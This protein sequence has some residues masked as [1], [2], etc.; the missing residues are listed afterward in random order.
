[1]CRSGLPFFAA[2]KVASVIAISTHSHMSKQ[3]TSMATF[4]RFV[5]TYPYLTNSAPFFDKVVVEVWGE[6]RKR[7]T[8]RTVETLNLPV[9]GPGRF[10]GRCSRRRSVASGNHFQVLYGI[11]KPFKN[12][13][14][15]KVTFWAGRRPV[16]CSDVMLVLES[17]MRR[18]YRARVSSV[19]VAFDVDEY[20]LEQFTEELCTRAQLR[21]VKGT[22][23]AGGVRSP[24]QVKFYNRIDLLSRIEFTFRSMFLRRHG[25]GS[26]PE[27]YLLRKTHLWDLVSFREVDQSRGGELPPRIKVPWARLERGMPPALPASIILKHLREMRIKPSR[28]VVPSP[29]E[30]LLR[31]M[32]RNLIF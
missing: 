29:R 27:L 23:Y 24:W 4:P 22:L 7:K 9:G 12:L 5:E 11:T 26:V 14:P 30:T 20:F 2:A 31:R 32:Q 6:K 19:E 17:L 10:Y 21:E 3:K 15:F 1:M 8:N 28:W 25:I 13:S 18:G 16:L